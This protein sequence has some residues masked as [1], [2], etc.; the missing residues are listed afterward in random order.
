MYI[1]WGVIDTIYKN[2]ME[3]EVGRVAEGYSSKWRDQ[4]G[5]SI[6]ARKDLKEVREKAIKIP[7]GR[8]I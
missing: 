5:L 7:R 6:M 2:K 3:R 4:E 8:I 1:V